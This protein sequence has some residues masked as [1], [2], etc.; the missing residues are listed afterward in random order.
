[1][2]TLENILN[3]VLYVLL[4]ITFAPLYYT[5]KLIDKLKGKDF[6]K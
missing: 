1:M 3:L 6:I 5:W 2:K 4:V